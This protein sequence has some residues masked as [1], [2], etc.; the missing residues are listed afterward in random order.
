MHTEF[1]IGELTINITLVLLLV[2]LNGVFVAAEFSLVKIRQTRITQLVSEGNKLA[3][4]ALKVNNKLDSYLSATQFGITLT[5]LALGWLGEP[6][7]SELL[8]EPIMFKLGITDPTLITTVGVVVGFSLITF[9][10]IVLGELAPKSI[11][12]Q[13][14]EG[15]VLALSAPLIFFYKIFFPFIWVLNASANALLRIIGIQPASEAEGAH[16]EEE[17]RL[18]M[19]QS[20]RNGVIDKEEMKL[21]DNIFEFSDLLAREVMLPRTD[22]VC[23]YVNL[24]LEDNIK[25]INETKHSRY[26]V[27]L[28]DKDQILGFIHITDLLLAN[29]EQQEDLTSMLRPILNVPE[30]MEISQVLRLMQKKHAQLTL[31]VDEYGGTAGILTAEEILEEIV[32]DLYD[33]FEDD[34]RENVEIDGDIISVKGRMLIEDVNDLTGVLIE[35][36]EV[37]SIGGW[38]FKELEGSPT[39]GDHVQIGNFIF[40]VEESTRLRI[41]RV[42]IIRADTVRQTEQDDL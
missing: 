41:T 25:I 12:L 4:F 24:P 33:E 36:N 21:M 1:A 32:G 26:P 35:D 23:L 5:S 20:A 27:A 17:I 3:G 15:T 42:M 31:V 28:E 6:A 22:M 13:R 29:K 10:H 38:L 18:L 2:L 30:S 8:V 7:I 9:L 14:T 19:S 34:E 37:D 40:Q 11:A 16:S 39:K